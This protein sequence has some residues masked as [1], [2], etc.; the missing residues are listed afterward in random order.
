MNGRLFVQLISHQ[1][2]IETVC[3][4]GVK[5][6]SKNRWTAIS[7]LARS[8]LDLLEAYI[9]TS[10]ERLNGLYN[11][12]FLTINTGHI[13][14]SYLEKLNIQGCVEH[15]QESLDLKATLKVRVG[16][17]KWRGSKVMI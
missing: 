17:T 16:N 12:P 15:R 11:E 13:W 14:Q 5:K 4:F 1:C 2:K 7:G 3:R 9:M 10:V 8:A 6:M